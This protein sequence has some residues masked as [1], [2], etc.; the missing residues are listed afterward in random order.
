M[1]SITVNASQ[2]YQ[3]H[4]G[5]GI[6]SQAGQLLNSLQ[7][8]KKAVIISDTNVYPLFGKNLCDH[9]QNAG[10]N[11]FHF[12][13][14]AGEKS[15]NIETYSEIVSFLACKGITRSDVLIAL[16]GGVVGDITGFAA[17]TYLRGIDYIQIPTSLLAMVDS[18]VGGKTAIDLSQ[19]KNLVGAFYQ[20]KMVICDPDVLKTLP[21]NFFRD[22][23]AE[24]IKYA[25]LFDHKLFH[26][27]QTTLLDFD[28]EKVISQCICF[29][30]DIVMQDEFDRGVRQLL[31]LG[32]TF[33]HGIESCSNYSISHGNAVAIGLKMIATACAKMKICTTECRNSIISLIENF[34]FSITVPYTS[35]E[36]FI[37]ALSDKKRS[38]NAINLILPTEIGHCEIRR[39]HI[40]DIKSI[41]QAGL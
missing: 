40:D 28:R 7:H 8:Y 3:I 14:T 35:D 25:V 18:S 6:L 29:K 17:A 24:I 34:G 4:I 39:Y 37:H 36:I 9:L 23:C 21:Q 5:A 26:H 19:G 38:D 2:S 16:G 33:G 10:M 41:I 1:N 31:N 13:F 12:C 22:G 32:H 20:P 30:R 15:K 11:V 27:L